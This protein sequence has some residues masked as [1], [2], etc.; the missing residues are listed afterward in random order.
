MSQ[1]SSNNPRNTYRGYRRL[2]TAHQ[3]LRL[4]RIHANDLK[5]RK[6]GTDMVKCSLEYVCLTDANPFYAL[7]YS[8]G[9]T[10]STSPILLEGKICDIRKN[11]AD[12]LNV[13]RNVFCADAER[14]IRVWA[15]SI[16][17]DQQSLAERNEQV[18]M[19]GDIYLAADGV[20]GWLGEPN[21]PTDGDIQVVR[22]I[23]EMR[24]AN[25]PW[26]QISRGL[27]LKSAKL[28]NIAS[29][30]YWNR[31]WIK[32]EVLLAKE[33]WFFYGENYANWK[34]LHFALNLGQPRTRSLLPGRSRQSGTQKEPFDKV[35]TS[36]SHEAMM[37]LLNERALPTSHMADLPALVTRFGAAECSDM[38]D[39]IYA[40]LALIDS[41]TRH[42][43]KVD[44]TKPPLQVFLENY[45][46]WTGDDPPM[47][48]LDAKGTK[49]P[50]YQFQTFQYHIRTLLSDSLLDALHHE[51]S[52]PHGFIANGVFIT[53]GIYEIQWVE[54][55]ATIDRTMVQPYS[56]SL[57]EESDAKGFAL[58]IGT[59]TLSKW[60]SQDRA[61]FVYATKVPSEG[62]LV[63]RIGSCDLFCRGSRC[64]RDLYAYGVEIKSA[65][66]Q[67]LR[68]VSLRQPCLWFRQ[69]LSG[70]SFTVVHDA[71]TNSDTRYRQRQDGSVMILCNA[72]AILTLLFE[73]TQEGVRKYDADPG[74]TAAE[75]W[76][77]YDFGIQHGVLEP[78]FRCRDQYSFET[79]VDK[80]CSCRF[81]QGTQTL[82]KI[83]HSPDTLHSS[84]Y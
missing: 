1:I 64:E 19:M 68:A 74:K 17:I 11:L 25:K 38:R 61:Y 6:N 47:L 53:F 58:R 56:E 8:W 52:T 23:G 15:D 16:C 2:D 77:P 4:L 49:V 20:Y 50:I 24:S 59:Q 27:P 51:R 57:V 5:A 42:K 30:A 39:K 3:E 69:R 26:V 71:T 43:I 41:E 31:L 21:D 45:P 36:R 35:A 10:A 60:S 76:S 18:S 79:A 37:S 34:D 9:A 73:S 12:F 83:D 82:D 28:P 67:Q 29:S 66:N 62:D 54:I 22:Q 55:I 40:L 48:T 75:E 81:L 7:S 65:L 44:Y 63:A 14:S 78:C 32:Q 72:A 84:V 13:L 70:A 80:G 46:Y 33:L